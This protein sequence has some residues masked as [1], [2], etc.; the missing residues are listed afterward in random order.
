MN[1]LL[2]ASVLV[3]LVVS[4]ARTQSVDR[5]LRVAGTQPVVSD[6]ALGEAFAALG[7]L[8]RRRAVTVDDAERAAAN[9]DIFAARSALRAVTEPVDMEMAARMV[10][11]FDL[12]LRMPDALYLALATRLTL[13]VMTADVTLARAGRALGVGVAG[14]E[15]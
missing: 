15:F 8:A 12:A 10:R 11:R 6:F 4:E 2:D 3:P 14:P 9:L 5:R 13:T 1:L 7:A